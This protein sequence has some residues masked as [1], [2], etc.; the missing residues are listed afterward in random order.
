MALH[1]KRHL[2]VS[3][4]IILVVFVAALVGVHFLM[5]KTSAT[6]GKIAQDKSLVARQTGALAVVASLKGQASQ[7]A[8]YQSAMEQLLPT[9]D[10]LID[11]NQWITGLAGQNQISASVSFNANGITPPS[12]TASGQHMAGQASFS[13]S[14]TGGLN[15][16]IFFL[17]EAESQA[18]GFLLNINSFDLTNT[19][20]AYQ[21]TGQG[22]AFFR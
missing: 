12:V 21:W 9:Q 13:L 15:N 2:I 8:A 22:V 7:A 16:I 5:N 18:S 20:G 3:T 14:A 17:N 1:L 4:G 10:G 6:V 19:N 11:F